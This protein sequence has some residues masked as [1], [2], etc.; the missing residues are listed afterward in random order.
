MPLYVSPKPPKTSSVDIA[1]RA[2]SM[3]DLG[4]ATPLRGSAKP[5]NSGVAMNRS[6]KGH[7]RKVF[8]VTADIQYDIYHLSSE[9]KYIGVAYIPNCQTSTFMN[10][11]FRDIKENKNLDAIEESDDESDFQNQREDKYVDLEKKVS[12]ECE[13]HPKFKQWVPSFINVDKT[14]KVVLSVSNNTVGRRNVHNSSSN[15]GTFRNK[16]HIQ[17]HDLTS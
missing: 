1:R 11:I 5:P 13:F 14:D 3:D 4:F 16:F 10:S 17:Q 8:S 2:I 6:S 12:M 7:E 9:T 15:E